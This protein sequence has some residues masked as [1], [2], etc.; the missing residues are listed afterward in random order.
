MSKYSQK[1]KCV[2]EERLVPPAVL[3]EEFLHKTI[4]NRDVYRNVYVYVYV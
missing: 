4:N 3:N 2:L 1:F